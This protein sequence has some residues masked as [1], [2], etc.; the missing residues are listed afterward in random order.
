MGFQYDVVTVGGGLGGATL[1][2]CLA[3]RGLGV[4]VLE[5]TREFK[6]RIRGETMP[7]WGAAEART[8]G[9]HELLKQTCG[10]EHPWFEIFLGPIQLMKRDLPSTTPH[11]LPG[12]NFY[13]PHM[14]EN[15]L[16][17]AA[18]AGAEVR[19]GATVTEVCQ[20]SMPRV[21][22]ENGGASQEI[23]ARLVVCADGRSSL[24]RRRFAVKQDEPY[25]R[26]AGVLIENMQVPEDRGFIYMNPAIG[27]SAFLFPQG[28]GRVRAY[29]AW[30]VAA[31]F[32]LTGQDDFPRFI[33]ESVHSGAPPSVFEGVRA[34]GPLAS[35]EAADTWVDHPYVRGVALLGDA[36]ESTDPSWG[37]GMSM[38][39]RDVRV[40]RDALLGTMNWDA[41]CHEYAREHDRSYGVIHEVTVALKEM[42]SRPGP[43]AD[44]RRARA[45]PLIAQNPMRVPDHVFS[46]PDLPWNQELLRVFFAEESSGQPV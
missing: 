45:L 28:G 38:T 34:I 7:P 4:L 13:H 8:L 23:A 16:N 1:A 33:Q 25:L 32:T 36:A 15:L 46:G 29:C 31:R 21:V 26:M 3:E 20:G 12:L 10:H 19:R 43:L 14:Q 2:K 39:L 18:A 11:G 6:D 40:L 27:Q 44:A 17:A 22:M 24:G 41:A 30:P 9:I 37:Q 35:F 5:Q 42:F